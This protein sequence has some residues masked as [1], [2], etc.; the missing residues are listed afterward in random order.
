MTPDAT[1]STRYETIL[2]VDSP[3]EQG[4]GNQQGELSLGPPENTTDRSMP[5]VSTPSHNMPEPD[6][7]SS[8]SIDS[9]EHNYN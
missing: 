5:T 9:L 6:T 8:N 7:L 3:V 2:P 1:L 4:L